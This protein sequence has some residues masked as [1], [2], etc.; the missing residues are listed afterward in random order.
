MSEAIL[1]LNTTSAR[2]LEDLAADVASKW[3]GKEEDTRTS[4]RGLTGSPQGNVGSSIDIL[5][6]LHQYMTDKRAKNSDTKASR[7][8]PKNQHGREYQA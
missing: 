7:Y 6:I 8:S 5:C 4:F 2:H 1:L 3:A